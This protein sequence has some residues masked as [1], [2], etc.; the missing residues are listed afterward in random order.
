MTFEALRDK[1]AQVAPLAELI[2]NDPSRAEWLCVDACG[3]H[4]DLTR[5]HIDAA[6]FGDLLG[7][8]GAVGVRDRFARMFAGEVVNTTEGRQV[9]HV[10]C[11]GTGGASAA[12]EAARAQ[13]ARAMELA[14]AVR[15]DADV[16]CVVNIGIGGSD[17]GPQMMVKALRRWCDGPEVRFVS[18]VD[19]ADLDAALAG[20]DPAHTMF[21]VSSKTFTTLETMINAE[22][23]RQWLTS[24]GIEW[25]TRFIASTANPDLAARWGI[26]AARCLEFHDWVGGR[27]SL[28]SVIG[29][30]VMIA[31][32]AA[33][34]DE[35]LGG[36]RAMDEHVAASPEQANIAVLHAVAWFT[37]AVLRGH[38]TVAV[39][40]Y[41]HDL[42]RL[43]AHLQQ[44]VMESNGKSVDLDGRRIGHPVAPVVWGE[45]GTNGQHAFFQMIHQ[46]TQV[47]PVE[48]ISSVAPMGTDA[49]AHEALVANMFAQ[50]EALAAGAK[51]VSSH[52]D[53]PGDRPSSVVMLEALSPASMGALV[54]MYE[55]STAV[56][57]WLAGV[58]SFDQFGVELGKSIAVG[59]IDELRAASPG[60]S[61]TLTHPLRKWFVEKSS[62]KS[63]D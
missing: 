34:F 47:V 46:G 63:A 20:L 62:G 44:L 41:A 45:P 25:S 33:V 26:P 43:P 4:L 58:N 13:R 3:V 30:P 36:M 61:E 7:L 38:P 18:N 42:A 49:A 15:A 6:L 48:F 17:L 53:F 12:V 2:A 8:V 24:A 50:A 51:G 54:A 22:R 35:M 21:I 52:Q 5:V 23:A 9:L 11:R 28:S 32:G 39:V 56:Q 27:F 31:A 14:E 16:H 60:G 37:N 1:A 57:G 29:L 10:A 40:P 55:H 19:P 59:I